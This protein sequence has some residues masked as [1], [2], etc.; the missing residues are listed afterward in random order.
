M[1]EKEC[2]AQK[3]DFGRKH[4]ETIVTVTENQLHIQ[5][6]KEYVRVAHAGLDDAREHLRIAESRQKD[7]VGLVADVLRAKTAV[8]EAEL[9][10]PQSWYQLQR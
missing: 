8:V 5:T 3:E 7:G 10:C 2:A 6:A 4:E 9:T 1:A